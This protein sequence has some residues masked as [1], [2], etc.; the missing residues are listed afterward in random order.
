MKVL[1][2]E[3]DGKEKNKLLVD[4]GPEGKKLA[5][6]LFQRFL[7]LKGLCDKTDFEMIL[8]SGRSI[9]CVGEE[10][11]KVYDDIESKVF[12]KE[13]A[14]WPSHLITMEQ[15]AVIKEHCRIP[16]D[17]AVGS[18]QKEIRSYGPFRE[19]MEDW[20]KGVYFGEYKDRSM[21]GLGRMVW[22]KHHPDP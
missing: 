5:K 12:N 14:K 22:T 21:H 6:E 20:N 3:A 19:T 4:L 7:D 16:F 9:G 17:T 15:A 13:V 11:L 1:R 10:F 2:N 18:D 8:E